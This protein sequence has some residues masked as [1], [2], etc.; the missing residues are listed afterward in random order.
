MNTAINC[1]WTSRNIVRRDALVAALVAVCPLAHADD[2]DRWEWMVAPYAWAASLHTD[3]QRTQPPA[4]GISSD[5]GFNNILDK[6][7]G[8]FQVH[9][10]GQNEHWGTFADFTYLG[11]ANQHDYA[12]FHTESDL[13]TRLFELAAV[14]SPGDDRF[15]GWDVFA[16]LRYIDVNMTVKFDPTNPAFDTT[17]FKSGQTFNDFMVGGRYTWPLSDRWALTLR[18][19]TS[20]GGTD[21]TWNASAVASYRTG[22]GAWLFG[23]RYLD[24]KLPSS[25]SDINI[26][27]YG[28]LIG[29]GFTF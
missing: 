4:G 20:F 12:R 7:D 23:Y 25:D 26:V 18:G 24:A 2:S 15:R 6:L 13:D 16:G 21:G 17:S 11:L 22:N 29:Y 28:P 14:W 10:E 1:N 27:M 19:D 9:V 8:V 3:L 5:T